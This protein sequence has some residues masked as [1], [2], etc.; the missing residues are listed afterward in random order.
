MLAA[1]L[2]V[3]FQQGAATVGLQCSVGEDG[4][5]GLGVFSRGDMHPPVAFIFTDPVLQSGLGWVHVRFNESPVRFVDFLAA[6]LFGQTRGSLGSAGQYQDA[7]DGGVES[8]NDTQVDV[9]RFL[10]FVLN[11]GFGFAKQAG[12]SS[13]D[14]HGGQ[15]R[16]LVDH[17]Q[18]VILVEYGK[19]CFGHDV[20]AN[21]SRLKAYL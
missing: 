11:I 5:L 13:G 4:F 19:R 18:M 3:A 14:S 20:T 7:G 6:K 17:Q 9:S 16:W 2:Q 1:C 21:G 15:S 10:V 12:G 8:A